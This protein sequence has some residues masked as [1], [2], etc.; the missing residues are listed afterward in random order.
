MMLVLRAT[1]AVLRIGPRI[2][3][4]GKFLCIAFADKILEGAG[5]VVGSVLPAEEPVVEEWPLLEAAEE[6]GGAF[7]AVFVAL[8]FCVGVVLLL[9]SKLKTVTSELT[10]LK[11]ELRQLDSSRSSSSSGVGSSNSCNSSSSSSGKD[12]DN[13]R[14]PPLIS[15]AAAV[16]APA[17]A[18]LLLGFTPAKEVMVIEQVSGEINRETG[19]ENSNSPLSPPHRRS[20]ASI[21]PLANSPNVDGP[22]GKP[23]RETHFVKEYWKSA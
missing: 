12:N 9:L 13:Q 20:K 6:M 7:W 18:S 23:V 15:A 2:V 4:A 10:L 16:P 21:S 22:D 5:A 1:V 11:A 14:V 17:I 3:R 19:K 8:F